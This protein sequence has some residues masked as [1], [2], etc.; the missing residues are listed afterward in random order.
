MGFKLEDHN[1]ALR[2]SINWEILF[3]FIPFSLARV[4]SCRVV[5][6]ELMVCCSLSPTLV[7]SPA[8]RSPALIPPICWAWATMDLYAAWISRSLSSMTW[9]I[10]T[11]CSFKEKKNPWSIN[12]SQFQPSSVTSF[13]VSACLCVVAGVRREQWP[14]NVW[15][16][17]TWLFDT[18]SWGL[19]WRRCHRRQAHPR[20]THCW[21]WV[22]VSYVCGFDEQQH[23]W[24]ARTLVVQFFCF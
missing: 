4:F 14:E 16:Y 24:T 19:V 18:C 7:L 10:F 3:S 6:G 8:W 9:D 2:N 15:L 17:V 23:G 1:W 20:V 21:W 12:V 11:E 13:T 22:V 5:I